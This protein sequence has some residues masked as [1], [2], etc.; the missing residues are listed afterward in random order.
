[1]PAEEE[2]PPSSP[3]LEDSALPRSNA[4]SACSG[5]ARS[6]SRS[7]LT[8]ASRPTPGVRLGQIAQ[9]FAPPTSFARPSPE[10]IQGSAMSTL[11]TKSP[12]PAN[13]PDRG[14]PV[15][16]TES[17]ES[18]ELFGS[19]RAPVSAKSPGRDGQRPPARKSLPGQ[20]SSGVRPP[21]CSR[22]RRLPRSAFRAPF[23]IRRRSV[24]GIVCASRHGS[25]PRPRGTKKGLGSR[26]SFRPMRRKGPR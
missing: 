1:M 18:A 9:R 21:S 23:P 2:E 22:L 24:R 15:V 17:P 19:T 16:S 25:R 4:L 7:R 8:Q 26:P 12:G 10:S 11:A 3:L 6:F 5:W 14:K 13:V 20:S